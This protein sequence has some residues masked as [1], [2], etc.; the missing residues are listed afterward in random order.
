MS[1]E[2]VAAIQGMRVVPDEV[3]A[4]ERERPLPDAVRDADSG[5][6]SEA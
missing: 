5:A 2:F 6:A 4:E 1:G 3:V